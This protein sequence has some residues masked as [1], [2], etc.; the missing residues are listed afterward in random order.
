M[1][2]EANK[3]YVGNKE[4]I[5]NIKLKIKCNNDKKNWAYKKSNSLNYPYFKSTVFIYM[6]FKGKI[7][8]L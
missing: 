3:K 4:F 7:F 1:H 6:R 8:I 2:Q 5:F